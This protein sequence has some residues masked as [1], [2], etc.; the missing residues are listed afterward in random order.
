MADN[1]FT[2]S[3]SGLS[4]ILARVL[5]GS[6]NSFYGTLP[7]VEG[8]VAFPVEVFDIHQNNVTGNWFNMSAKAMTELNLDDNEIT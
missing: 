7:I 3:V 8:T 5:E 4:V 2:M 1:N 6:N